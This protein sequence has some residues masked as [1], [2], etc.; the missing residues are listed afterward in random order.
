[1]LNTDKGIEWLNKMQVGVCL[2]DNRVKSIAVILDNTYSP[3]YKLL[4]KKCYLM[5]FA[6]CTGIVVAG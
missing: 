2:Y 4:L 3:F 1:M 6:C 5:K